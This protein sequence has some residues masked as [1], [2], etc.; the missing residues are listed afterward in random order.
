MADF[1]ILTGTLFIWIRSGIFW[2]ILTAILTIGAFFLLLVNKRRKLKYNCLEVVNFGNGKTGWNLMKAGSFGTHSALFNLW[3][4]G[5][6]KAY[7][8]KDGRIIYE[9]T[10]EDLHDVFG[11]KGFI[12]RRK[13]GDPKILLPISKIEWKNEKAM[14]EI[15]PA[16]FRDVSTHLI[17]EAEKETMGWID[18]YLPYLMI[19]GVIIFFVISMILAT[20]FFNRTIDK[21]GQIM[22]QASQQSGA[23]A[24]P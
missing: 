2:L 20:Q 22:L 7:K 13:D 15:A 1:S 21:A 24:A 23:S 8:I 6:E 5:T 19:G 12:V 3:D 9:A 16:E 10:E 14:F 4:Y 11:K 17:S 18:K